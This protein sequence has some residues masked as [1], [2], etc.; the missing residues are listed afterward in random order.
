MVYVTPPFFGIWGGGSSCKN[1]KAFIVGNAV[2]EKG[3]HPN[4][5]KSRAVI[6]NL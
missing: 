6:W 3:C 2:T 4:C 1:S 5:P